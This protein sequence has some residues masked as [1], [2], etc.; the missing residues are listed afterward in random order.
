[1]CVCVCVCVCV[2][3]THAV[4]AIMAVDVFLAVECT[5][6]FNNM[7]AHKPLHPFAPS[8]AYPD[9]QSPHFIDPAVLM[10]LRLLSQPPLFFRQAF[11]AEGTQK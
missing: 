11:A 7:T 5:F 4:S 1:M 8:L 9:G 6:A 2:N 3:H 10:H